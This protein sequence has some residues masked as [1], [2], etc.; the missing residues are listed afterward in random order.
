MALGDTFIALRRYVR[1]K[2]SAR[3]LMEADPSIVHISEYSNHGLSKLTIK[4]F[5][6]E[7][8][9]F[10]LLNLGEDDVWFYRVINGN[11]TYDFYDYSTSYEDFK[12]GH[13]CWYYFDE[14]NKNL[15][16]KICSYFLSEPFDIDS[17]DSRAK[18]AEILSE[19]FRVDVESIISDFTNESNYSLNKATEVGMDLEIKK[20]LNEIGIESDNIKSIYEG[21]LV[22]TVGELIALYVRSGDVH[23]TIKDFFVN[24]SENAN[25]NAGGWYEDYYQFEYD[26]YFDND[27]FNRTVNNNLN[28]IV[29]KLE[30]EDDS[31]EFKTFLDDIKNVTKKFKHNVWYSLPKNDK[32]V[33]RI[34][35]YDKES[36]RL[37]IELKK[38]SSHLRKTINI[39][40][41]NFYNLLYQPELFDF[42]ELY[43]NQ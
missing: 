22:F 7:N 3:E 31:Q 19:M 24:L 36:L 25:I 9:I 38:Q 23:F 12:N 11:E 34:I 35:G 42:E 40:I 18:C 41:E 26:K 33:F 30:S 2:I 4:V 8:S 27:S 28:D 43:F 6:D 5:R 14:E 13:G 39:S 1:G 15:I 20:E 37:R 32:Y 10:R 17:E 21:T 29:E 16:N